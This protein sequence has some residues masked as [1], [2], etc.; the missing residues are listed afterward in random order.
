MTAWRLT[1]SSTP[2]R[3]LSV[4][5]MKETSLSK[6]RGFWEDSVVWSGRPEW[7]GTRVEMVKGTTAWSEGSLTEDVIQ[8]AL[9]PAPFACE[10]QTVPQSQFRITGKLR[11]RCR[12]FPGPPSPLQYPYLPAIN[13]PTPRDSC[14]H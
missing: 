6:T 12:E 10:K 8:H 11:G 3:N 4:K 2:S 1:L 9:S 5:E 13:S 14:D 7:A